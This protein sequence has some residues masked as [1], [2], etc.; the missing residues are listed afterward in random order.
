MNFIVAAV[1]GTHIYQVEPKAPP[2]LVQTLPRAQ[3]GHPEC[4]VPHVG[5][6]LLA[7]LQPNGLVGIWD[8]AALGAKATPPCAPCAPCEVPGQG[9]P[10]ARCYFSSGA[11]F[12]VTWEHMTS[13]RLE[14]KGKGPKGSPGSSP[15]FGRAENLSVWALTRRPPQ[16]EDLEV[17]IQKDGTL[18]LGINVDHLDGKSGLLLRR[19]D[20]EGLVHQH[21]LQVLK[22]S[23]QQMLLPGDQVL[24]VNEVATSDAQALSEEI[25]RA[26]TL[27]LR[28]KRG[29]GWLFA[30]ALAR[31][32]APQISPLRWPPIQWTCTERFALRLVTDEVLVLDGQKPSQ[33][34]SRIQVQH[35]SQLM[36]S[37]NFTAVE[38]AE[39]SCYFATFSPAPSSCGPAMVRVFGDCAKTARPVLTKGLFS[40]AAWVT[41][42]WEPSEGK[43]L[44]LL[45]HSSELTEEDLAFRTLHGHGA[46]GLYL[47]RAAGSREPVTVLTTSEEVLLDVEWCRGAA[48][49]TRRIVTLLGPQP[50]TVALVLYAPGKPIQRV[51][52][53]ACMHGVRNSISCDNFG[54]SVCIHVQSERGM[55]LSNEAD[56]ADIFDLRPEQADAVAHR[57]A[58]HVPPRE[59][60]HVG[61]SVSSVLFSPDGRVLLANV[62][63]E[64]SSELRCIS[65]LDG[66]QLFSVRFE[67]ICSAMWL[68]SGAF[69]APEFPALDAAA[70]DRRAAVTVELRDREW[71][72]RRRRQLETEGEN[73]TTDGP[74]GTRNGDAYQVRDEMA[75]LKEMLALPED[76]LI[77]QFT[78]SEGSTLMPTAQEELLAGGYRD[79]ALQFCRLRRLAPAKADPLAERLEFLTRRLPAKGE[80]VAKAKAKAKAG[81]VR[82]RVPVDPQNAEALGRR[83]RALQ[84][85]LR[86]IDKLKATPEN[87]LD[88]LQREKM[89]SEPEVKIELQQLERQL[90]LLERPPRMIFDVETEEGLQEIHYYDGDDC[91]ELAN[92]FCQRYGLERGLAD[93]LASNMQ[94]RL[95]P[96]A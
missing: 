83:V 48:D 55:G 80:V 74:T 62:Q 47:L 43:D 39:R 33:V 72:Q 8:T 94:E 25:Q 67:G 87:T 41:M 23:P 9:G 89:S 73:G 75:E 90:Q 50:A 88:V 28:L 60:E 35:L 71:L 76:Q 16:K 86:E 59:R 10:I 13:L 29:S 96:G 30:H 92:S 44:L 56:S 11:S 53:D 51:S 84:K 2:K 4:L 24:A 79:L 54:R 7:M 31:F 19:V 20:P 40:S 52:L 49:A 5:S 37:P 64:M 58:V 32:F 34:L 78:C 70:N 65:A 21:N 68:S 85:K 93:L 36:I 22:S 3:P 14:G 42:K 77:F 18:K 6:G 82:R 17:T 12:L 26:A 1:N 27:R 61:P 45:V 63:I 69:E 57:C 38:G 91:Y 66:R 46:N 95:V 81:T 15:A